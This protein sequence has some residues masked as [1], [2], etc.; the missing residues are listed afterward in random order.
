MR[1][2]ASQRQTIRGN[3]LLITIVTTGLIGFLL[4]AYLGL[5]KSQNISTMRSQAWNASIPVIEAGI[6]DALTHIN[7][8][9]TNDLVGDG[10][11]QRGNIYVTRRNIGESYYITTISNWVVHSY[12]NQPVIESRGYVAGPALIA[13]ASPLA[14]VFATASMPSP[15]GR[16]HLA[17]G[18]RC[19]SRSEA[20]FSKGLVANGMIDLR[21]R[22]IMADSYNSLNTN[23]STAG[24][25]DPLKRRG[26]GSI[27]TNSGLTNS[28]DVGNAKVYGSVATGP[29]G[30]I[31]IGPQGA[32]GT[33]NF[34]DEPS[35]NGR[36]QQ[37]AFTDDMNVDFDPVDW[38]NLPGAYPS[39]TG[40]PWPNPGVTN[41]T[42]VLEGYNYRLPSFSMQNGTMAVVGHAVLHVI[43]T[44]D[45]GGSAKIV[46]APGASL[47][48]YV[49]GPTASI[50]G[51]GLVNEN[52]NPMSFQYY[53][54][55]NNTSFALTGNGTFVGTIYA[56]NADLTFRGGGAGR[57]DFSGAAIGRTAIMDGHFNFHYDEALRVLSPPR[58]YVVTSWNEMHPQEVA[59]TPSL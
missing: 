30:S 39:L 2:N 7:A 53:G 35:N 49:G 10:W 43:G 46:I 26:N 44:F 38:P 19:V 25:Y 27:A 31:S 55:R 4:S 50:S 45:L 8:R 56:P 42:Y 11:E 28:M 58:G 32:V 36:V 15:N 3:T 29:G 22:N 5:V 41:Y 14:P 18:I 20:L 17:R 6:E 57:E 1:T 16:Q 37:G 54:L 59:V 24:R 9:L 47:T 21:G 40:G 12:T 48:L 51:G 52:S 33:T 34:V 13:S 23:Y